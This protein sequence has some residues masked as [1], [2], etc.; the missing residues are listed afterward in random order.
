MAGTG[1]DP[2]P[3][4]GG[5]IL[6]QPAGQRPEAQRPLSRRVGA[7]IL[8]EI[9]HVLPATIYFFLG[10]NLVL[11]TKQLMLAQYLIQFSGFFIATGAALIVGKVVLVVDKMPFLKRY[12]HAP[13]IRPILFKTIVYTFFVFVARLIEALIHYLIDIGHPMGFFHHMLAE[14]SW[15]RFIAVQLWIFVLF[16]GYVTGSEINHL[17][18]DGELAKVLFTRPSSK[19]KQTRRERIRLLVRLGKLTQ[20]HGVEEL[21]DS[22]KPAHAELSGILRELAS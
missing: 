12:D 13:L 16:L 9:R 4:I 18:G 1:A 3:G 20:H 6:G 10:F 2:H 11:L 14:F 5:Q 15:Q 17:F 19:L 8:E 22:G 21:L 7:H